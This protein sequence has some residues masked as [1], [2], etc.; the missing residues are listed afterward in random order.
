MRVGACVR[1]C[2]RACVSMRAHAC[3]CVCVCTCACVCVCVAIFRQFSGNFQ[4]ICLGPFQVTQAIS[5]NFS[6]ISR[7]LGNFGVPNPRKKPNLI[8]KKG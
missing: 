7:N 3:M 2:V 1:A 8:N 6:A 4:A 5:G